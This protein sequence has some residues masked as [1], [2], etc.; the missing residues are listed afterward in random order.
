[1]HYNT[2]NTGKNS[3]VS[4]VDAKMRPLWLQWRKATAAFT[5]Q[6]TPE[7]SE[8]CSGVVDL[9]RLELSTNK[10]GVRVVAI[11]ISKTIGRRLLITDDE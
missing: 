4:Y 5:Q 11:S 10:K 3:M 7:Q 6:K 8:L 1:M 9:K 2:V